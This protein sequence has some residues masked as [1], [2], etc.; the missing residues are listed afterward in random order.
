MTTIVVLVVLLA[1]INIP[2][3]IC[4]KIKK[5]RDSKRIETNV[6]IYQETIASKKA[7][8]KWKRYIKK[9]L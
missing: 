7:F 3:S 8:K 5:A 2:I 6:P 4:S 9:T 1:I